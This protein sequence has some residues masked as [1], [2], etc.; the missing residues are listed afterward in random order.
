[1]SG[2]STRED[3]FSIF[4]RSRFQFQHFAYGYYPI[5]NSER[6]VKPHNRIFFPLENPGGDKNYIEVENGRFT[7]IPGKLYFI[8][9]YA[10][11]VWRLDERLKFLSVHISVEISP[12]IELFSNC[13]DILEI[14]APEEMTPLLEISRSDQNNLL[15]KSILMGS[16]ALSILVKI[17]QHYDI[18]EFRG[19]I[20]LRK[21]NKLSQYLSMHSNAQTS[22]EDLAEIYGLSRIFFTRKF[23]SETGITPKK[24]IDRYTLRRCLDMMDQNL[25]IK[26]ISMEL[27]FSN[28]FSFS[29]F[30]KRLT[31]ES[32]RNWKKHHM[33][34]I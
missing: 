25:S 6:N 29:R 19:A 26:E 22:V 7:M 15:S 24:L 14:D 33:K 20:F 11:S 4:N 18:N 5:V 27:Q 8:P 30:F 34:G 13:S 10:Q 12:G 28:E 9:A 3:I 16:L 21:Y 1:M 23:V 17:L 2:L 31:G 32:P